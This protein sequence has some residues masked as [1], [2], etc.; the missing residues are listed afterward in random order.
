MQTNEPTA[1]TTPIRP[2][3]A[4]CPCCG[5]ATNRNKMFDADPYRDTGRT[6][7]LMLKALA[8]AVLARGAKVQFVDHWPHTQH[9]ARRMA[10][11]IVSFA[12][13]LGLLVKVRCEGSSVFISSLYRV[14]PQA[15]N[16]PKEPAT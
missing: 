6:T 5:T 1:A 9:G 10:V 7:G 4:A 11:K 13:A 16:T 14:P 8:D 12:S 3:I 2:G 15:V